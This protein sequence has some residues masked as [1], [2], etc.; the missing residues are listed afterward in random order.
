MMKR[1]SCLSE[2]GRRGDGENERMGE[3]ENGRMGETVMG[4]VE[5]LVNHGVTPSNTDEEHGFTT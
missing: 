2:T 5:K 1:W 3:W 4:R